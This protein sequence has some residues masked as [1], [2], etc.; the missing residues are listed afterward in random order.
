LRP[1]PLYQRPFHY[2]SNE[3]TQSAFAM[4]WTGNFSK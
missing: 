4:L 1:L 3:F 2:E